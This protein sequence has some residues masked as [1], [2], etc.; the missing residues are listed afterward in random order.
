[1]SSNLSTLLS[2]SNTT[3]NLPTTITETTPELLENERIFF[4]T[5]A[6]RGISGVFVWLSLIITGHQRVKQQ[7]FRIWPAFF[8]DHSTLYVIRYSFGIIWS[9]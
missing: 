5:A 7:R 8:M 1:M 3:T 9:D 4:Q 2:S 6:A